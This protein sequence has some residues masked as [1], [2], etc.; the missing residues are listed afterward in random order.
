M[1]SFATLAGTALTVLATLYALAALL[2]R[3]RIRVAHA[4]RPPA[5]T[6]VTVL[7]PLCGAE[8]RLEENL[9]G[10]CT[11][12]HPHVQ[13]VFGVRDPGDPAIAVVDR[14]A[15]RFPA[16]DMRL[17][18]DPRVH[19]S[20]LKVSNLVNMMRAAR[21][22]WLVLADSDI[23]VAPDYVARVTA[24]LAEPHVGLVTCLYHGRPLDGF[25]PRIGALFID[26]WFAPSVRVASAGGSSAFAFGATIALRAATLR[27]I[28]GFEVLK[29][30]LADDY[31]L[32]ELTRG[33]GLETVLSDVD[34]ATDV[35]EDSL[36]ALWT[37]ERRWMQTIRSLN[38]LGYA[39]SFITFTLPVLALGLLLAP[40]A[41]NAALALGGAAARIGLHWRQPARG[42]PVPGHAWH[43]PL[44]DC[45]LLL[46]WTSAFIGTTTQWRR[47]RLRIDTGRAATREPARLSWRLRSWIRPR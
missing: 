23:A 37:R 46:E 47:H 42:V 24:P 21:H 25:W 35:T 32:G 9:A 43:A 45:L 15:R 14:L 22:P 40:T 27:A 26:T 3:A 20:N 6:P 30:R 17:V 10:L 34:V 18:V 2:C 33:L 1:S 4:D 44:R 7:K 36:R 41:W 5:A 39:F 8:P 38:P 16:V 11:Q 19:G 28:G 31:R 13:L 29:N 12:T